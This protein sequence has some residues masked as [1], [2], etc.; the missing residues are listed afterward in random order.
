MNQKEP[1]RKII[2]SI[3]TATF[4]SEKTLQKTLDS[5]CN[6]TV[7][8]FEYII[9]DGKSTDNTMQILEKYKKI[10]EDKKIPFFYIS[11]KDKGIYD[12]WNKGVKLAQGE[13]ISFIGSDDYYLNDALET[14]KKNINEKY[15]YLHSKV[16]IVNSS[17]KVIK[18]IGTPI[19][20][21][22][23]FRYMKIAHVGSF[24]HR[25]LFQ[26]EQFSLE[27]RASSDYYFFLKN[28]DKINSFFID[29]Y[30]AIMQ[31]GGISTN[32]NLSLRETLAVKLASKKSNKYLCY[33]DYY[34]AYLKFYFS[35]LRMN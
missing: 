20:E 3:I 12:A 9:I 1:N 22:D 30:T 31:F 35:K 21:K 34:M 10:F 6:Q 32:I 24:H 33:L 16:K 15:N 5:L 7:N 23:F 25:D 4:N 14:Y 29:S 2:F 17:G 13:W 8:D 19:K 26:T 11:E 18:H 28:F 27:Y